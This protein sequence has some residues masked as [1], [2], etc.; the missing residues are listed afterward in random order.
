MVSYIIGVL[1]LIERL[2]AAYPDVAKPYYADNSG[3]PGMFDN[4]G[5]YFNS[6]KCFALGHEYY[7]KPPKN[8][9]I[10][11]PDNF[12]DGKSLA[13]VA[14]LMF[15]QE[16]II[17]AFLLGMMIYKCDWLKYRTLK[18]EKKCSCYHWKHREISPGELHR[19]GLF[20][21][22]GADIFATHDK[23]H[24]VCVCG[25]GESS[26]G[27]LFASY[28]LEEFEI[29]S[30]HCRNLKYNVSQEAILGLQDPVTSSNNKYLSS[31]HASIDLVGAV[32]GASEFL[33]SNNLMLIRE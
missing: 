19:G 9:L 3:G 14:G 15:S 20:G 18:W 2:K 13:F 4:I 24:R 30:T 12:A 22:T 6:L 16:S 32:K 5:L 7:P 27:N 26:L 17:W 10:V 1:P 11:H 29:S 28:F 21:I 8:V 31:L 23:R 33:A 25:R